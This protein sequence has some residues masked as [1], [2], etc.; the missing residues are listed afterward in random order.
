MSQLLRLIYKIRNFFLFVF[1]QIICF[2]LIRH[3]SVYWDVTFFN[4]SNT[5]AAKSLELT[6]NLKEYLNLRTVN[7]QLAHENAMM[8]QQLT[9]FQQNQAPAGIPYTADSAFA[10]RFEFKVAKV[11]GNTV[12]LADNYITID[13]GRKDG[14]EPGMGVICPQGIVGQVMSCNDDFSI[15]YSILHSKTTVSSE[16]INQQLRKENNSALGIVKWGGVS[17]S[18]L[19]L[20]TIDRFKPVKK[21]D[22]VLTSEQNSIFP[23][24]IMIGRIK[25]VEAGSNDAFFNIDVKLSTDFS[26][27]IY[28]YVVKNKLIKEQEKV[29]SNPIE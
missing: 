28:V 12:N 22:S 19:Q 21:G 8:R 29:G 9:K 3:N 5:F 16:V 7:K 2:Y 15:V 10:G 27:L 25:S 24:K 13:K 4:S 6:Y 18:I 14:I 11:V 1:L 20:T 26:S 17:P 23:S